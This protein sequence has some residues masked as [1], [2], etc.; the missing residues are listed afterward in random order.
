VRA[1][2]LLLCALVP[3]LAPAQD[4]ST[5]PTPEELEWLELLEDIDEEDLALLLP[6]PI[7]APDAG[8]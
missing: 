5:S 1:T 7:P 2:A 3:L 6:E 4:R 8:R